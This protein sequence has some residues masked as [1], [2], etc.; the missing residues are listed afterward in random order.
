MDIKNIQMCIYG[1]RECTT[2]EPKG[3]SKE[4]TSLTACQL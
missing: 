4:V 3:M 1:V 2:L